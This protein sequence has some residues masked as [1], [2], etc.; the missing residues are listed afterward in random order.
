MIRWGGLVGW[1]LGKGCGGAGWVVDWG[2]GEKVRFEGEG[3]GMGVEE[4]WM[5]G[6]VH[7]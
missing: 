5:G 1:M 2:V 7:C 4:R 3:Q 6:V